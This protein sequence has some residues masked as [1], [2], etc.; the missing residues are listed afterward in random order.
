MQLYSIVDALLDT[1]IVLSYYW[2]EIDVIPRRTLPPSALVIAL[3]PLLDRALGRRA[4]RSARA[5][6]SI[7]AVIDVSPIPFTTRPESGIDAIAYDIWELRREAL[8]AH[9]QRS[10]VAVAEWHAGA[11]SRPYSRR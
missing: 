5:R 6:A 1:Q 9:A 2:K 10:G 3:S 8:S 4:A 7:S 11:G